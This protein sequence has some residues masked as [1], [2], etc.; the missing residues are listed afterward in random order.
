MRQVARIKFIIIVGLLFAVCVFAQRDLGT[1]VG[2][3][4]DPQGGA[5]ANAKV[6]IT[7]DAT[8]L[9]YEVTTNAVGEFVRPALKPGIYTISVEATGFKKGF[10]RGVELTAG[11]RVAVPITLAVGDVTQ[12]IEITAAA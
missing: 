7:E 5:I 6:T 9:T 4:T 3:V 8:A 1:I 2:T 11:G 10:Q 12:S